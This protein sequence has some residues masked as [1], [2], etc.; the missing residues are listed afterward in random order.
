MMPFRSKLVSTLVAFTY[1]TKN[2]V[3]L[4]WSHITTQYMQLSQ[5]HTVY[6]ASCCHGTAM[7]STCYDNRIH[8]CCANITLSRHF[9]FIKYIN[10][11]QVIQPDV[12]ER[13]GV[14]RYWLKT[15]HSDRVACQISQQTT[16]L[17][18]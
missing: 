9:P 17:K 13:N 12:F 6:I 7:L 10:C 5:G 18:V 11:P 15:H 2:M 3:T 8:I 1:T 14:G 16:A 4:T